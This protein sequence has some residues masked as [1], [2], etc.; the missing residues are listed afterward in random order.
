[1]NIFL[2]GFF[3]IENFEIQKDF[4]SFKVS[5]NATDKKIKRQRRYDY[6]HMKKTIGAFQ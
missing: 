2:D 3:P 1:M 5:E 6:P 4:L